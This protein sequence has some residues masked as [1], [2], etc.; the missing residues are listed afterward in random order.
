MS[1]AIK[2]TNK[3]PPASAPPHAQPNLLPML[4]ALAAPVFVEHVL[5]MLV[6]LTDTYL[7]N[8]LPNGAAAATAAVGTVTYFLWFIGLIAGAVGTGATAL[9]ARAVGAKHRSLANSVTGQ[10]VTLALLVGVI[11]GLL[12]LIAAGPIAKMSALHDQAYEFALIYIKM[13]AISMPFSTLM[14]V[15]GSALRGGGDTLTPAIAMIVVDITNILC[16][17]ALCNG[18]WGLPAMG[19]IGI[20]IGT[21]IAYVTGGLILF[22]ALLHGRAKVKLRLHRMKLHWHTMRRLLKIGIPS[23]TEGFL[24]WLA[25]FGVVIAINKADPTNAMA[26]AH[27]NTIRIESISFMTGLAVATAAATMVGQS[28]GANN[29]QRATRSAYLGYALG[30]GA[31]AGMG[32][33]FMFFGRLFAGLLSNDPHIIEL[34][35]KCLFITGMI[36]AGFAAALVF[37]GALRGAGDTLPVMMLTLSTVF[38]VRFAGVMIVGLWLH[39]GLAAIWCVLAGELFL[40]GLL[41]FLRFQHGGWKKVVV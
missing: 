31:M 16:T 33:L 41:I 39:L 8:H 1:S 24:S 2:I 25:N 11:I 19:F 35:T 7:A 38:V 13:L 5:H 14:F 27:I 12:M 18:W 9:I 40:R 37:G 22:V 30:G 32:L 36:Q 17:F 23:G 10:S 20:A 28:L 29:P 21:L 4:I 15:G 3:F 26:A 34:T 6:G